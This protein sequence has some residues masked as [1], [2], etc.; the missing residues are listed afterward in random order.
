SSSSASS[1]WSSVRPAGG[2]AAGPSELATIMLYLI[3][4]I[5]ASGSDFTSLAEAPLYLV[6]GIIVLLVHIVIMLIYAKLTKTELFSI[7]VASTANIG[8]IASAPVVAGA[9][10]RQLVPVGVLFALIGAF[11][12]TF[13]GLWTA[14]IM[15]GIG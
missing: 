2:R 3:I 1:A 10:N 12:G 15:S 14:Q 7:A 6:A 11:A 8:G 9:F 13:L 5:I 4:G